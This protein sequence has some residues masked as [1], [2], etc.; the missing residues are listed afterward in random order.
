M[1]GCRK[2]QQPSARQTN[3]VHNKD[4]IGD[5]SPDSVLESMTKPQNDFEIYA[6]VVAG[7]A[8][9]LEVLAVCPLIPPEF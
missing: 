6:K 2:K 4:Q 3:F 5:P 1:C 7:R 8:S 9:T